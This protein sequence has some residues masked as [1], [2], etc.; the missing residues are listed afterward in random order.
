MYNL[1]TFTRNF[2]YP[3]REC[4]GFTKQSS[5]RIVNKTRQGKFRNLLETVVE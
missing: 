3:K 1:H 2:V 4:F 5:I